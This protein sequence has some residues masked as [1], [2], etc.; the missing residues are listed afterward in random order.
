MCLSLMC[1]SDG[2]SIGVCLSPGASESEAPPQCE[3]LGRG[4][5]LQRTLR[6]K[7][8][9][10]LPL[11]SPEIVSLMT[12]QNESMLQAWSGRTWVPGWQLV[13]QTPLVARTPAMPGECNA[14]H[15]ACKWASGSGETSSGAT[16][17]RSTMPPS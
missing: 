5:V 4:M 8:V 15:A 3:P 17:V 9:A 13:A 7:C 1:L 6:E 2:Q 16:R 14:Q 11:L 12:H 10:K